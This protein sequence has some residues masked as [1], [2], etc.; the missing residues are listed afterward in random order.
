MMLIHYKEL[1]MKGSYLLVIELKNSK[2]IQIGKL[3]NIE[4]KK[5]FYVYIGS[6]FNGVD[7]RIL[8]HLKK[9][10]NLHWHVDYLLDNSEIVKVFYKQNEKKEECIFAKTMNEELLNIPGFGCSD[11]ACESHLFY[12]SYEKISMVIEK[13]EIEQYTT[14][15]KS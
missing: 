5:G 3:R 14:N 10:K 13:L 8:R 2:K 12:G 6:A 1:L 11:C 4:F 7:Q 9:H 15:A